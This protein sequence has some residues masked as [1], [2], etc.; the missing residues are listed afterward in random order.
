MPA[1]IAIL[2][3]VTINGVSYNVTRVDDYAFNGCAHLRSVTFESDSPVTDIG[4]SAF[5]FC[6]SLQSVVFGSNVDRFGEYVFSACNSVEV[7]LKSTTP[8]N[9]SCE[10]GE[11]TWSGA[12]SKVYVPNG[13]LDDYLAD[14]KW[15]SFES[16]LYESS[17]MDNTGVLIDI[18]LP[19]AVI[20]SLIN[21]LIFVGFSNKRKHRV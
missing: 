17:S 19:V 6:D 14:E 4:D 16:I 7:T 8:P 2:N 1:D 11:W 3:N 15:S 10:E 12:V 9:L 13:Y 21:I 5:G 18:V 20:L